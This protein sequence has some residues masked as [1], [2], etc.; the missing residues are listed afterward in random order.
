[1]AALSIT[2]AGND[3]VAAMKSIMKENGG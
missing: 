3:V 1:M 2:V